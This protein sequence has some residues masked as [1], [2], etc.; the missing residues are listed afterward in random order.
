MRI[1]KVMAMV[2]ATGVAAGAY[3]Q[4]AGESVSKL[5]DQIV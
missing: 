4:R 5:P 2:L 1:A 3:A